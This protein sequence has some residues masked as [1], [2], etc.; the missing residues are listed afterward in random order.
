MTTTV[1]RGLGLLVVAAIGFLLSVLL[2]SSDRGGTLTWAYVEFVVL[3][4]LTA[5]PLFV[6]LGMLALGLLRGR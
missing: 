2:L 3:V 5:V 4:V 6:G 1:R